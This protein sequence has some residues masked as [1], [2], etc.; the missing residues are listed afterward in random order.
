MGNES[1]WSMGWCEL[2][3]GR[4]IPIKASKMISKMAQFCLSLP[5]IHA[6]GFRLL[7]LDWDF[8]EP[9]MTGNGLSKCPVDAAEIRSEFGPGKGKD[10]KFEPGSDKI[11]YLLG[12]FLGGLVTKWVPQRNIN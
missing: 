7:L 8:P 4:N 3:R 11:Q 12:I 10:S 5:Q 1:Q 9:L 2:I 6:K